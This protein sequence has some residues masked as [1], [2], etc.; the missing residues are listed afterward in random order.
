MPILSMIQQ[1]KTQL[2]TRHYN[3]EKEVGEV[4]DGPIC[5]K[6]RKKLNKNVQFANTCYAQ[7]AGNGIFQVQVK[8]RQYI[9]DIVAKHCDCRRW[10]LT[11]I[12]C[13]HAI[14]CL[15]H[16]RIS[17]ESVVHDCY[18]TKSFL[19]AYGPKIWPCNDQS[20]WQNVQGLTVLPPVYEKKVGRPPKNRRKQPHEVEGKDGT[21]MSRHGTIIT[22]SYCG[23]TGHNRGGCSL[24][25]AGMQPNMPQ[26]NLH[27]QEQAQDDLQE[28]PV[29]SQVSMHFEQG[30]QPL[31]SQLTETMI[32]HLDTESSQSA[33]SKGNMHLCQIPHSS[34]PTYQ[35]C[36]GQWQL[37][38][39]PSVADQEELRRLVLMKLQVEKGRRQPQ[40]HS[41]SIRQARLHSQSRRQARLHSQ[42]RRQAWCWQSLA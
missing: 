37:P 23:Q 28:E 13:S 17:P 9:V 12:P 31:L 11:G 27:E 5:P 8:E 15:R 22:C 40:L 25:K 4:W 33:P 3:K 16:E 7:P 29:I 20:M 26:G 38:Q 1:V 35:A 2:M 39:Q 24:R 36:L 21:K 34:C 30:S 41:Q 19:L 42:S 10:D 6:I 14:S 18:S 32:S